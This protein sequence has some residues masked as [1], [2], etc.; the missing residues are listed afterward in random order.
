MGRL[1]QIHFVALFLC[2]ACLLCGDPAA[3]GAPSH[4]GRTRF[5]LSGSGA[6]RSADVIV[7]VCSHLTWY[8]PSYVRAQLNRIR[9][10]GVSWIRDDFSWDRIEHQKGQYDWGP[11]DRLMTEAAL[12][13]I[14]VVGVV[15]YS[16]PW[17]RSG[18]TRASA[19]RS[20]RDY[21]EF[22]RAVVLRY[23]HNGLFWRANP[24]LN[25]DPLR[26]IE[27]WNE[28]YGYWYWGTD[29]SPVEY[30][31]ML[32]ATRAAV[33]RTSGVQL[34]G[35]ANLVAYNVDHSSKPWLQRLIAAAPDL[36]SLVNGFDVHPY[37]WP[38]NAGPYAGNSE[39]SY[40]SVGIVINALT[41]ADL[42]AIPIW[43][44]EIGWST[45]PD[46]SG[47]V[48]EE[49]QASFI[50]GAVARARRQWSGRVSHLFLYDWAPSSGTPNLD[51]N[52]GLLDAEGTPKPAWW[53]LVAYLRRAN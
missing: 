35:S 44:T 1:A 51:N 31:E 33:P 40:S 21:A 49:Q 29:P 28:P 50:E 17:E 26:A 52:Y 53:M 16:P 15:T 11:T 32:R 24:G 12:A 20:M 48:T 37:P 43:I 14:R 41:H 36:K 18:P 45:A 27:V 5:G 3:T 9:E 10:G 19:P 23:G 30:A 2:L 25:A 4:D 47:S 22:A 34:L 39:Y 13:N 46:V 7:G 38:R 8:S 42:S 6:R